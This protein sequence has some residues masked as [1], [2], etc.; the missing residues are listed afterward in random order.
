MIVSAETLNDLVVSNHILAHEEV[1]DAY[2]HISFRHPDDP[3][4][5]L[6]S[7]ARAPE[8]LENRSQCRPVS[9]TR[10]GGGPSPGGAARMAPT[11]ASAPPRIGSSSAGLR[12]RRH[13]EEDILYQYRA[14]G[15][16]AATPRRGIGI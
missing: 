12:P 15:A 16:G 6:L 13:K 4:R 7:R 2:G 11:P 14:G 5:Y 9:A 10:S 3:E 1:V 8:Q